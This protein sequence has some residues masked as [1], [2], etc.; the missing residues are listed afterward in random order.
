MDETLKQYV[1]S[2]VKFK[3]AILVEFEDCVVYSEF[4]ACKVN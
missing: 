4:N 1:G 2:K 3:L